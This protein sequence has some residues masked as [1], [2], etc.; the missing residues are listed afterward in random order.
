MSAAAQ[1]SKRPPIQPAW[2]ITAAISTVVLLALTVWRMLTPPPVILPPKPAA[3]K[4][5]DNNAEPMLDQADVEQPS[6]G[7]A[8]PRP[9]AHGPLP[10]AHASRLTPLAP[11]PTPHAPRSTDHAPVAVV[12][13]A[14]RGDFKKSEAAD[15]AADQR[16]WLAAAR[17]FALRH[18][19]LVL[20][21]K[22]F[23][24]GELTVPGALDAARE[25]MGLHHE[26]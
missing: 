7:Q 21:A 1:R 6:T 8:A 5:V 3:G 17:Q 2:V 9:T 15:R 12:P 24:Q 10:T 23:P 18:Q 13:A 14:G 25:E 26:G 20:E 4:S 11:R 16:R 19:G 22:P